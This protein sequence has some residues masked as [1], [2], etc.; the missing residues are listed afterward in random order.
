MKLKRSSKQD[1]I[2]Y[3]RTFLYT[4][5]AQQTQRMRNHHHAHGTFLMA[6]YRPWKQLLYQRVRK[7]VYEFCFKSE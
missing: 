1:N 5:E 6:T 7:R 2:E 4:L 3:R